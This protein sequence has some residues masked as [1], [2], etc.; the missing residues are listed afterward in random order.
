MRQ[1]QVLLTQWVSSL[2]HE[3]FYNTMKQVSIKVA[4][5]TM[6]TKILHS[7]WTPTRQTTILNWKRWSRLQYSK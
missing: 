3:S 4:I 5:S 6:N 2:N 1:P 7:L